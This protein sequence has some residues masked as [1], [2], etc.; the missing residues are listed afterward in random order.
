MR[1]RPHTEK[2]TLNEESAVPVVYRCVFQE[3]ALVAKS[4][5]ESAGIECALLSEGMLDVNPLFNT[6]VTGLRIIVAPEDE[7]DAARVI[8]DFKAAKAG[9]EGPNGSGT[10]Q[11]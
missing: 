8:A 10:K 9:G 2:P 6:A 1:Q 11:P 3:D 5:L 7:E 4:L